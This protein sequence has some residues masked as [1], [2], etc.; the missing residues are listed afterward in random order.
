MAVVGVAA[1]AAKKIFGGIIGGLFRI[2]IAYWFII[3]LFVQA[4]SI[5][6]QSGAGVEGIIESLGERFFGITQSLYETA[7]RVIEGGGFFQ[8]YGEFFSI[9]WSLFSN[10]YL[11]YLWVRLFARIWGNSPFSDK[12]QSFR[13]MM[14][15]IF[16][17][18]VFQVLYL[19]LFSVPID[20]QSNLDLF[21]IP[22]ESIKEVFKAIV[23][24]FSSTTFDRAIEAGS[25]FTLNVCTNASG[26]VI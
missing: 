26:C 2:K 13:N 5:G 6:I 21:R 3:I 25:N 14:F 11:I 24:I 23:L 7:S 16:T 4:V 20:S 12:L 1:P 10:L 17:F 19:L 9:I 18:F 15:G 22:F 8:G